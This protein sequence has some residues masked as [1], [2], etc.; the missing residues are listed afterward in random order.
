MEKDIA[1]SSY[2]GLSS[3]LGLSFRFKHKVLQLHVEEHFTHPA[4]SRD[5]EQQAEHTPRSVSM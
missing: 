3:L 1:S 4:L 2:Q 5:H